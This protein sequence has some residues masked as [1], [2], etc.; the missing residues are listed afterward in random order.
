MINIKN[1]RNILPF[2]I[3][4]YSDINRLIQSS[5]IIREIFLDYPP[6]ITDKK[7]FDTDWKTS[8]DFTFDHFYTSI[9]YLKNLFGENFLGKHKII[10]EIASDMISKYGKK[11]S[12]VDE[13]LNLYNM[14]KLL[15][16]ID[17]EILF[18][19]LIYKT[20][21]LFLKTYNL[22]DMEEI[23]TKPFNSLLVEKMLHYDGK[24]KM[25]PRSI[26]VNGKLPKVF[27][28]LDFYVL[29]KKLNKDNEI[30]KMLMEHFGE[31]DPFLL[32]EMIDFSSDEDF[33]NHEHDIDI[34]FYRLREEF[35]KSHN[36]FFMN[37]FRKV[38]SNK[39]N[40]IKILEKYLTQESHDTNSFFYEKLLETEN[41]KHVKIFDFIRKSFLWL[42]DFDK[43]F[44]NWVFTIK[45]I[46]SRYNSLEKNRSENFL[47]YLC[48]NMFL[49]KHRYTYCPNNRYKFIKF[50]K[51]LKDDD[52]D[53]LDFLKTWIT[54]NIQLIEY[55]SGIFTYLYRHIPLTMFQ[56]KSIEEK[57]PH[58][59]KLIKDINAEIKSY[60]SDSDDE[61][62]N[63]NPRY[64][65]FKISYYQELDIFVNSIS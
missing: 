13:V 15:G 65:G 27:C 18:I 44:K 64:Y 25:L 28:T 5:E 48:I 33:L 26:F 7:I 38:V 56:L 16:F 8:S 10:S 62:D 39:N 41:A 59:E 53:K 24:E 19:S 47:Y 17:K 54:Q 29:S 12:Y 30:K 31:K 23:K 1:I 14:L 34:F 46:L 40:L 2:Q 57:K 50:C 32:Y 43:F 20:P 6:N 58:F 52:L 61:F 42:A 49:I 11:N 45:R 55:I 3:K 22:N 35:K 36:D 4:N 37:R 63:N 51:Y 60:E 21:L 9:L